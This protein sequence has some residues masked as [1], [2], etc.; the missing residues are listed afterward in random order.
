MYLKS[1]TVKGFKSF[2]DR[3][4]LVFSPG[5][6]VVV[7][8]NGSGKSNITD[9]VLWALGEQS[10]LAVRGQQMQDVIFSGGRGQG[11]RRYAEVEVVIDNSEGRA[12]TEFS[13][14]SIKRRL[15]RG[16]DGEY[17]LNGARCRL[18][19]IVD[20]L[21]DTNLGREMHSVISQ[22]RVEEIVSSKPRDRRLL[23]EEAAGLGKHRKRRRRAE[24]KL[25]RTR[26]NLDRAHDVERE[27]RSR[28]RPLK[29]Q[30]QAAEVHARL[31]REELELRAELI[32]AEL[33]SQNT[34]LKG[35]ETAATA[36]REARDAIEARLREVAARREA[37]EERLAERD[38]DRGALGRRIVAL[39]TAHERTGLRAEALERGRAELEAGLAERRRQLAALAQ[40]QL[41][42]VEPARIAELEAE[43]AALE[44]GGSDAGPGAE[45]TQAEARR[46]QLAA[47]VG[48][49]EQELSAAEAAVD[50][51][52]QARER[53][54]AE[55][56]KAKRLHA[57]LR[58][59]LEAV[60][61]RLASAAKEQGAR[62]LAASVQAA[63]GLELALSAV[64]GE[65]L[66]AAIV[67]SV[68]EGA[69]RIGSAEG[70]SRAILRSRAG[71]A[72][73][74]QGS[75]PVADARPLLELVDIDA[76]AREVAE[77]LLG[78]AWLVEDIAAVPPDF[79]GVA[80]TM[81]G[82]CFDGASGE[83]R[84]LP[85]SAA[86][87]ALEARSQ[88]E[89][90]LGRVAQ[91]LTTE[92]RATQELER[93]TAALDEART[94]LDR[95]AALLRN[96]QRELASAAEEADKLTWLAE[97][98][99]DPAADGGG[100]SALRKVRLEAEL[101][102]ERRH[103][104]TAE[105]AREQR[106]RDREDLAARVKTEE[107]VLPDL[108]P[109]RAALIEVAARIAGRI[110][111]LEGRSDSDREAGESVA[112]Q[113]RACSREEAQIQAEL[114]PA[115]E[116]VTQAEVA[117]AHSQDRREAA[118]AELAEIAAKLERELAPAEVEL[119]EE[120]R[121]EIER[122]LERVEQR[123]V[124]LGPVNPLA[125]REYESERE[126]V[127]ELTSER[128]DVEAAMAEL[129]KLIR[130]TDRKIH[131]AFEQTFEATAANFGELVEHLF[132]G[133]R[134]R[135]RRM[136]L[137]EVPE[138]ADEEGESEAPEEQF[139]VEIEVTPAGKA[140]KRL[141]LLSG[142]EKS[143]VALA[144]VF[145]VFLARPCPFYILDEVEAALDD[146]NIDRFLQLVRRFADRAQF[147]IVTHQKRTMDAADVLYGVSMGQD[148]V[149]KVVS[150]RL[151]PAQQAELAD[152]DDGAGAVEAAA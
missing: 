30:A 64:L 113:L 4:K 6:S 26:E 147:V 76:E 123:R 67:D 71:T 145:A 55:H 107:A 81:D 150:K 34:I 88:R 148:G 70:A 61:A 89:E 39:R 129:E 28:L 36:A 112:E 32:A 13:E 29:Q 105:R 120:R 37:A 141:S 65:R 10:P 41:D 60:E 100:S 84:R 142:G 126:R 116:A 131:E 7:G 9:A 121:Q 98:R 108:E 66:R 78:G 52:R 44:A 50:A 111:E 83:L 63:P 5:V 72:A 18:I 74:A 69:E 27:A 1:L 3:T 14:I 25:E 110:E 136:N 146:A 114:R 31:T 46:D 103:A 24:L 11:P 57:S 40:Q 134:G 58:G 80:V 33:H 122:K 77:R 109:V 87:P 115:A 102:A 21:A 79:S 124:K 38:R 94:E 119:S 56:E 95:V 125:E 97:Q 22:G 54:A 16:G 20:V 90:L 139:G 59:E 118:A 104:E 62:A 35:A 12:N 137:R 96:A 140:M 130:E 92:Q 86:D 117:S 45:L 82:A 42:A 127:A 43:I 138:E 132:P 106:E 48:P 93:T 101:A 53:A 68:G 47:A 149:T 144:F 151:P 133:G 15:E 135:L 143:L 8:P 17:R 49:L 128:E 2:P 75:P 73:P 51:A 19:D 152:D 99:G 23:I 91:R 85:R